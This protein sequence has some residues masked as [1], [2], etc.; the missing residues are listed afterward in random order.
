MGQ[1]F[2]LQTL[3]SAF[4]GVRKELLVD[5]TKSYMELGNAKVKVLPKNLN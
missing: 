2:A 3:W 4:Y 5:Q 1:T